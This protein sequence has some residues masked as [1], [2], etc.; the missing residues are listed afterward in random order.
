MSAKPLFKGV[1]VDEF[2]Q[3]VDTAIIGSEPF[4][5]VNDAGFKRHVPSRDVDMQILHELGANIEG[6]E[7]QIADQTAKMMGQEDLFTRAVIQSQLKNLDKQF[8]VLLETGIPEETIAYLGMM[9]LRVVINVHGDVIRID[10][11]ASSSPD[12]GGEGG[13]GGEN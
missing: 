7:D 3:P 5:V 6:N 10:Q 9:G 8:E 13:D 12:E 4:Y 2:D 11:P 1:I